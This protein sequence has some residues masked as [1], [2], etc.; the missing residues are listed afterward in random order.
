MNGTGKL[1][2]VREIPIASRDEGLNFFSSA[3]NAVKEN[4]LHFWYF[5]SFDSQGPQKN[6]NQF[7]RVTRDVRIDSN[8]NTFARNFSPSGASSSLWLS[9]YSR[10]YFRRKPTPYFLED[11]DQALWF[12]SPTRP[13]AAA[14]RPAS[15]PVYP[16]LIPT[17][18]RPNISELKS[19]N[20]S[21][22]S[23]RW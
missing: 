15:P 6:K 2:N 21:L 4:C 5:F 19:I 3:F 18:P 1:S 16:K 9:K 14:H 8:S 12:T 17:K 20:P 22:S 23:R 11:Q 7:A 10:S 13:R